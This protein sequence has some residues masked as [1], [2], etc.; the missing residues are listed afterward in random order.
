MTD[1]TS[2]LDKVRK[3]L[4][5]KQ[6]SNA[7]EAANAAA[8]AE[9]L[10]AEHGL[11][12]AELGD[13]ECEIGMDDE[14]LDRGTRTTLWKNNLFAQL[15][16]LHGCRG[17]YRRRGVRGGKGT[18]GATVYSLHAVGR[19]DDIA[20]V[21]FLAEWLVHE[22]N[23]LAALQ[24]GGRLGR[25]SYRAG[26]V[27]GVISAMEETKRAVMAGASSTALARLE[28]SDEEATAKMK[29]LFPDVKDPKDGER[30]SDAMIDRH[31]F[32]RGVVDGRAIQTARQI[33][34]GR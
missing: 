19:Q 26:C 22:I 20:T 14:P 1:H 9:R 27:H 10:I 6:S 34:A 30:R 28:R 8:A 11:S 12:E 32:V 5:L 25:Q 15:L 21:R 16:Q 7:H 4:A 23:R 29:E 3:L 13:V 18:R 24:A 17:V 2:L 31:A 33:G